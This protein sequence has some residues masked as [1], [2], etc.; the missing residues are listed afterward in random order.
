MTRAKMLRVAV[1]LAAMLLLT[2]SL[3][4]EAE[5]VTAPRFGWDHVKAALTCTGLVPPECVEPLPGL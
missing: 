1:A 4:K 2:G 5:L 3:A